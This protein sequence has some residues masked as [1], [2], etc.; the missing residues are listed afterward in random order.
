VSSLPGLS[1]QT[2]DPVVETCRKVRAT[3]DQLSSLVEAEAEIE[4]I[5][6]ES[7]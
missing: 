6:S 2:I 3:L 1:V 5:V 7:W 4:L